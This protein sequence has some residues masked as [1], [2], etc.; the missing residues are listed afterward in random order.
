MHFLDRSCVR[1]LGLRRRR[2]LWNGI[3]RR[4]TVYRQSVADLPISVRIADAI[5][6][7]VKGQHSAAFTAVVTAPQVFFRVQIHFPPAVTADGTIHVHLTGSP[8]PDIQAEE[9][10]HIHNAKGEIMLFPVMQTSIPPKTR[11]LRME[12]GQLAFN[13]CEPPI[14]SM[15]AAFTI[16]PQ[17]SQR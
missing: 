14:R 6:L 9:P 15:A 4:K 17:S 11:N 13:C 10:G 3:V 2:L 8:P 1:L 7:C 12:S 16:L 5:H